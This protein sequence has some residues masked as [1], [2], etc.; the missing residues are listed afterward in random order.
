MPLELAISQED[1]MTLRWSRP[2]VYLG[3]AA[4][5]FSV[6]FLVWCRP[7]QRPEISY[8]T[9]KKIR[10]GMT[11]QELERLLGPSDEAEF[12]SCGDDGA[13]DFVKRW[14][15]ADYMIV[16]GIDNGRVVRPISGAAQE[17]SLFERIRKSFRW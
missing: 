17:L 13:P 16:V 7:R 8:E 10:L 15:G 12:V 9:F 1:I 11:E 3:T 5:V 14:Y 2:T 4:L 6:C